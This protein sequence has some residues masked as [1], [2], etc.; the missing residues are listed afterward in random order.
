[1]IDF[2]QIYYHESQ[3]KH[4]YPFAKPYY[5]E[6]LT[7]FFENEPISRLVMESKADK[8]AVCSWRLH[9]KSRNIFPVTYQALESN[10][11]VMSF[12]IVSKKHQMIAMMREWH[13]DAV[14][15]LDMLWNKLGLKRPGEAKYPIYMNHYA[16]RIDIYQDYVKNFL[17]PAMELINTDE[18]LNEI[19]LRPSGY[20]KLSR[21]SDLKSV[22]AK[23]GMTDYPLCPFVL[24]RCPSLYYQM[25][26]IVVKYLPIQGVLA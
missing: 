10:Y 3:L 17:I 18:Q 1:M 26:N 21:T 15:A 9:E 23:L 12:K 20:R 6:G 8:I 25:K 24:E 4:L 13:K 22:Q 16:A 11:E 19:M 2:H 14:P 5:N 7:I